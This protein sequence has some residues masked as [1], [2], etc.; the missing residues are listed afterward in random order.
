[1]H[2]FNLSSRRNKSFGRHT[3]REHCGYIQNVLEK[4]TLKQKNQA[5]RRS[6]HNL[7]A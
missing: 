5:L 3:M 7:K 1:M 4:D 2:I 6:S